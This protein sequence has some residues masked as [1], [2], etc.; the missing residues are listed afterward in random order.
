MELE[1][2]SEKIKIPDYQIVLIK[3]RNYLAGCYL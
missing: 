3:N 1:N 2:N